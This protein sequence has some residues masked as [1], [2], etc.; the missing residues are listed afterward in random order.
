MGKGR[1]AFV[2]PR[3]GDDVVGGAETVLRQAAERLAGRGWEVDI[4]TTCA[5]DHYT[6]A[7]AYPPGAER[8][9]DLMVHRFPVVHPRDS[10]QWQGLD[11]RI[12]LGSSLST[13]EQ[14]AWVNGRFRVPGLFHHLVANAHT[15]RA[16]VFS[17]YL[18]WTTV[19]GA[20]VAPERTVVI[21]C[22]HDE[23]YAYLPVFRPLLSGS[24]QV[25]FM[26]EPEHQL[27]HR[28]GPVAAEHPV[29]GEGV[30][31]PE[32]YDPDGFRARHG[33]HRP[34]VLFA[35]RRESGKGWQE[36]LRALS[37]AVTRL[38]VDLDLVTFGVGWVDPPSEIADR[39][40]N[41]GWLPD[42]EVGDAYAAAAAY[43]QPSLFESF[44][45]TI[46]ESWL[47]GTPVI[48]N[49]ASEV[50]RWHCE[51]SGAGLLYADEYELAHY[52]ALVAD[53][54]ERLTGLGRLGRE[55]VLA[56]YTWDA[57]LDRMEAALEALP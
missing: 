30:L 34:Y 23:N 43:I 28:I 42:E 15:Y 6:W 40:R 56:N 38:G 25:W 2:P 46:M 12:R 3:Y 19:I 55:Y 26:S 49:G 22:L 1:V 41:L 14:H 57:A 52:L 11:R 37:R 48:A 21:P 17:P 53:H 44:S 18:F 31:I 32:A 5:R 8:D 39:V 4:L 50:V 29:T 35:G 10:S 7:N 16:I 27:A 20:T 9:G 51:R 13:A 24:A 45:R 54:P 36:L 33:L 47:A